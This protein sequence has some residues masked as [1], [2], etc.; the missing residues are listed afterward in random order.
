VTAAGDLYSRLAT[1]RPPRDSV[2][3]IALGQ[4]GFAIRGH[5]VL[6]LVDPFLSPRAE[7]LIAPLVDPRVIRGAS[8]VLAT[9]EHDD[10]LDLPAWE[11]LA[12]ASPMAVF[13][14]PSPLVGLVTRAGIAG[15]RV[16]GA[17]LGV[18]IEEATIRVTAV[19]A[20]HAVNIADGYSIGD[21]TKGS[22]RFVG[23]LIELE[24]VRIYH[25]GDTLSHERIVATVAPLEPDIALV[26]INGRDPDRER[27]G[28]VGNMTADEA[29]D[30]AAALGV[31]VAV[32][33]HYDMVR[34]NL[35]RPEAFV[36][37]LRSRHPEVSA[38]VPGTSG[39]LVWPA[40]IRTPIA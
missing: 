19:P 21:A 26:P 2:G 17:R 14:V 33:M 16:V 38:W 35:G 11:M 12:D 13:V 10:H 27:R 18:M 29:A 9:H 25:A 28:V 31:T 39:T 22:T 15:T 30:L 36:A 7:R 3:I 37:A 34:G 6:L 40:A 20:C 23:Y 5:D 32:P 8:L 4:A 24:G 1:W